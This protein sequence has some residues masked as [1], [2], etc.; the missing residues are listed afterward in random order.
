MRL[1][2]LSRW[3]ICK[4]TEGLLFFAQRADELLFD[5]T[6]DTYK[7]PALNAPYL[8]KE[9]IDLVS[10]IDRGAIHKKNLEPVLEELIWS[11]R[12]DDVAKKL[13]N[14]DITYYTL[15]NAETHIGTTR[16]RLEALERTINPM[17]YFIA[18][19]NELDDAVK[20]C[21]KEK[22]Y[23]TATSLI[24]TLINMGV[25]KQYLFEVTH[26]YFFSPGHGEIDGSEHL[27][28]YIK[29]ISSTPSRYSVYFITSSLVKEVAGS[30]NAF[31][32]KVMD[33]VPD[34]H[35]GFPEEGPLKDEIVVKVEDVDAWDPYSAREEAYRRLDGLRDLFTLFYHRSRIA[36]RPSALVVCED[37]PVKVVV[38]KAPRGPMERAFDPRVGKASKQLNWLLLNSSVR[39]DRHS[40][41]RFNRVADLH[42]ICVSHRAPDNQLV[43]LWTGIETLVPGNNEKSKIDNAISLALPIILNSYVRKILQT[44][45]EDLTRWDQWRTKKILKKV[46]SEKGLAALDRLAILIASRKCDELRRDLYDRLGDFHLLRYRCF[47]LAERFSSAKNVLDM[48]DRH[49]TRVA[50]QI[51]RLYRARNLI[52]HTSNNP[53]FLDT[54]IENGHDYLDCMLF[55][56]M[57]LS[58][59]EFRISTIEQAFE[60]AAIFYRK[61]RTDI[62]STDSFDS[63]NASLLLG[64]MPLPAGIMSRVN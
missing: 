44:L 38:A 34:N 7:P 10:E 61:Y 47:R 39:R 28:G 15:C 32:L 12:N 50:W 37:E 60:L 25:S 53:S 16:L 48:L 21:H 30:V 9:A 17:R 19:L 18:L 27:A 5:F 57:W 14:A 49:H 24:T 22:I 29:A 20:N 43:S 52:V 42:G 58:C 35:V 40:F 31:R 6:L 26:E 11:V 4:A 51:R 45:L 1:R 33:D 59:D 13:L 55:N 64:P 62:E 8:C 56:L 63:T 3:K 54:L 23:A 36:W 46:N 2:N 41:N